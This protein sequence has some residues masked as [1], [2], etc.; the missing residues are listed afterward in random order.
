MRYKRFL[1]LVYTRNGK[2]EYDPGCI[3]RSLL[4]ETDVSKGDALR[5]TK[6]VTR[7]LIKTNLSIITA[8]LIREVANVQLL[9]MGLERIRLQYTR[10]GMP[11]YDIKGLKE[12]YHDINEILREIGEWTLWEYDAVDEL[13]SKK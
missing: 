4:R 8:P 2:V 13:I 6:K 12:K 1:P 10:L 9:K 3:Y 5:V 7:V 11:K